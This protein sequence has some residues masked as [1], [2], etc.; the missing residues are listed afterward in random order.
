MNTKG[1]INKDYLINVI[2]DIILNEGISNLSIRKVASK[3]NISIGGIQYIFGNK[4]G[5][6][7]AVANK[8][9]EKYNKA[10]NLLLKDEKS[11]DAKVKAHIQ[12][13][14]NSK[15]VEDFS[16]ISRMMIALLEDETILEEFQNWYKSSLDSIDTNTIEGKKLRLSFLFLEG[17]FTL[18]S[19]KYIKLDDKEKKEILEDLKRFLF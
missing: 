2:E 10:I 13:L 19:F 18:V 14:S 7:K 12:Y 3:A 16:K 17:L 4:D 15:N 1:K 6:I 9:D 5:M 8:N 11:K